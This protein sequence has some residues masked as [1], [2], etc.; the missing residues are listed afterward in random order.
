MGRD[1]GGLGPVHELVGE[2][3]VGNLQGGRRALLGRGHGLG[4]GH[5]REDCRVRV[6]VQLV[7]DRLQ[8]GML[9][10][11]GK[12]LVVGS[13][14]VGLHREV[15]K[16]PVGLHLEVGKH[17]VEDMHREDILEEDSLVED[18]QGEDETFIWLNIPYFNL[19]AELHSYD[20][21]VFY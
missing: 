17:L 5:V 15:G 13:L 16:H 11:E 2:L 14:L 1:H 4:H 7:R 6:G 20:R 18:S 19:L 9:L 3:Q 8:E 21:L 12:H 10:E